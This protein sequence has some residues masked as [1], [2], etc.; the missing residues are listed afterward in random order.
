MLAVYQLSLRQLMGR[1]RL[2]IMAVLC[3]FPVLITT[4]M[5]RSKSSLS[6]S[7]FEGAVLSAMLS[8][9]IGPL[10]VLA[11]SGA[12]FANETED[13][14]LANLTLSP[15]P[16]WQIV[17][18][19][20]LAS[21]TVALPFIGLSSGIVAHIAFTADAKATIAVVAASAIGVM[22]YASFF[23]YL[24]LV[25]T[26]AIGLG[27]L[28]IVV[29]EGLVSSFVAGVRL[30]SIRYYATALMHG[31]D[32]RRFADDATLPSFTVALIVAVVAFTGLTMLSIRRLR[33]MDIP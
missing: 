17:L 9:A 8:G 24:G 7:E 16:R 22:L 13:R 26:H 31:L 15:L 1:L 19:K 33:R 12:A 21:I 30:L 6:V 25:T 32:Q 28:Y 11:I 23:V 10:V 20:L 3:A 4:M 29:W 5:L 2:A 14:T 27:L 18:P